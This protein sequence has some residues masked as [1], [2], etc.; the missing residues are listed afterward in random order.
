MDIIPYK[1]FIYEPNGLISISDGN[2]TAH[3]EDTNILLKL[4][5]DFTLPDKVIA[6]NYEYH[7]KKLIHRQRLKGG[8]TKVLDGQSVPEYEQIIDQVDK[9][10]QE[11]QRLSDPI[12][13][14]GQMPD[15]EAAKK[16]AEQYIDNII[17]MERAYFMDIRPGKI[18][19]YREKKFVA[20]SA[21]SGDMDAQHLL[22]AE[23]DIRGITPIK[24]A[25]NIIFK[26]AEARRISLR[27]GAIEAHLVAS[28]SAATS[29]VE[30]AQ[31]LKQSHSYLEAELPQISDE[32]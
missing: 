30:I 7:G 6:L 2:I 8:G 1:V 17:E 12:E 13:V 29:S 9:F 11:C 31:K 19:E 20:E 4:C 32:I 14:I 23:A 27:L 18:A 16:T 24:L 25:Q 26:A 10:Y 5:P 21:L 22:S 15:V 3:L 28:L